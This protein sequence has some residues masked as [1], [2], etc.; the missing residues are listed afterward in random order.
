MNKKVTIGIDRPIPLYWADY[1]LVS[2]RTSVRVGFP[3][4]RASLT[5]R[6]PLVTDHQSPITIP[7]DPIC[8][9]VTC[10]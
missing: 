3:T 4:A 6:S 8:F 9:L 7:F 1:A 5:A 2:V 10:H